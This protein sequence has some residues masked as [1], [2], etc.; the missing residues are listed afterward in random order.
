MGKIFNVNGACR[1]DRH[2]MVDLRQR[3]EEIRRMIEN[4]QYFTINKARQYGKTTLLRALAGFLQKD[5]V[6]ISLDFQNIESDEFADGS[7]FVHALSREINKSPKRTTWR[8]L[9]GTRSTSKAPPGVV[10]AIICTISDLQNA[11]LRTLSTK[12]RSFAKSS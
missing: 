7:S 8:P 1:P 6:V 12:V 4:G 3:L 2:Y 11:S 9:R 5:Y 10:R